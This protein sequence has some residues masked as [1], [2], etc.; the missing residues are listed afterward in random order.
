[1]TDSVRSL[2]TKPLWTNPTDL[3]TGDIIE[4]DM[5]DGGFSIIK[6]EGLLSD[7]EIAR[8]E[9]IPKGF[10]RNEAVGKLRY[11]KDPNVRDIGKRLEKL[12]GKYR[13]IF[14]EANELDQKDIFS[15]KRDAVFL[16]RYA[17][18]VEFGKYIKFKEKHAYDIYFLLGV[19][20]LVTNFQ[21]RHKTCEVYYNTFTDDVA[22]KGIKDELLEKYHAEFMISAVKKYLRYLSKFDYEGATKFIVNLIDD[23]KFHRLPIGYYREFNSNSSYRIQIEGKQYETEE[24][25]KSVIQYMDIRYNFNHVLVPMLNMASIGVGKG[26]QSKPTR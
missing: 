25:D 20:E 1:M 10:D 7:K 21:S 3:Y 9:K 18:Q 14:G 12:F 8:L 4:Y 17:S 19:D 16:T 5:S 2:L 24:A 26:T 15:I 13:V 6:E 23:Y 22:I 11:S